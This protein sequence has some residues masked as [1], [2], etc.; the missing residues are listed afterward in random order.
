MIKRCTF[1]TTLLTRALRFS[2]R[3]LGGGFGQGHHFKFLLLHLGRGVQMRLPEL[4]S[5]AGR[6]LLR[7]RLG[8]LALRGEAGGQVFRA[9]DFLLM[10]GALEGRLRRFLADRL[11]AGFL[12]RP[13]G[14]VAES[15]RGAETHAAAAAPAKISLTH[16]LIRLSINVN[17]VQNADGDQRA[18]H[19]RPA[20][21]QERQWDARHGH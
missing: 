1:L 9:L 20:I 14:F 6:F 5:P 7:R 17:V 13:V 18:N 4:S 15:A 10:P 3:P 16:N 12:G 8:R 19:R 21:T 11:G 2:T